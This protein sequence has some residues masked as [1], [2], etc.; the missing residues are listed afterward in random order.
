MKKFNR[1]IRKIP[2]LR[3][4]KN[5]NNIAEM[6]EKSCDEYSE[7]VAYSIFSGGKTLN[8]SFYDVRRIVDS[9]CSYLLECGVSKGD[10]VAILSENRPEWGMSYFAIIR[11]GATVIPLDARASLEANIFYMNFSETKAIIASDNFVTDLERNRTKL[12]SVSTVIPIDTVVDCEN[13]ESRTFFA[14]EIE[15]S[16]T[17]EILF[18][19]GTTGE[20]KGVMLTHRNIMSNVEDIY[21]FLDIGPG[22]TA[23]SILPLHHCYEC[24]GGLLATFYSGVRVFYARSLRPNILMH[25]LKLA[26]PT[27]WMN[28]P[29]VLEKLLKR[30][31]REIDNL[32]F[33]KRYFTKLLP[34]KVTGK[35]IKQQLGLENIRYIV[36]G[37]AA[38]PLWVK[39]GLEEYG[40]PLLQ[41]YGLSESAPLIS[42]N[43][44]SEPRNESAGLIITSV[45]AE[46][47]DIDNEGNGE[48]CVRG[49]NIM[50]GYYENPDA[51]KEVLKE[52]GWLSTGDVGYFDGEGYL[53]ITGRKKNVIVTKSGKNIY[54]EEIE[55]KLMESPLI[56][57]VLVFSPDD[58]SIQAL[59]HPNYEEL[60]TLSGESNPGDKYIYESLLK[61]V[62][63]TNSKL[64][65]YKRVK[66]IGIKREEFPKTTTNKIQRYH[67]KDI[68]VRNKQ[69]I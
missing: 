57:E 11:L 48:I 15:D 29:L 55:V 67:F 31:N 25:D 28:T 60:E 50:S 21:S 14:A 61:Q 37:G 53:Y 66:D 24:T 45:E 42:A 27:I 68:D 3:N 46:I 51:T 34:G 64:E 52:D 16:D 19:S 33:I 9:F 32:G 36:S 18:T 5:I 23:F 35:K 4:S 49:P 26:A 41:G 7:H 56:E 63:D 39:D 59:I 40:F 1:P 13:A 43:P 8:Y 47:R 10:K 58:E 20:P 44:P 2:K 69:F 22:D 12:T 38:L 54:P 62:R 17:S 30:I 65:T 6:F